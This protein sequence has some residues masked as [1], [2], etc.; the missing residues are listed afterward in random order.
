MLSSILVWLVLNSCLAPWTFLE[1]HNLFIWLICSSDQ[2]LMTTF[3]L[4]I[5]NPSNWRWVAGLR[6]EHLILVPPLVQSSGLKTTDSPQPYDLPSRRSVMSSGV[7][8]SQPHGVLEPEH[9][10]ASKV[11]DLKQPGLSE[12]NSPGNGHPLDRT[13]PVAAVPAPAPRIR[14]HHHHRHS[15]RTPDTLFKCVTSTS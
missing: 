13:R 10:V 11:L 9:V 8:R 1:L 12:M 3:S 7:W 14:G 2:S 5:A 6:R 15:G 4:L